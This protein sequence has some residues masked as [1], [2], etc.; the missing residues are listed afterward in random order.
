MIN[1][2]IL[3]EERCVPISSKADQILHDSTKRAIEKMLGEYHCK[4]LLYKLCSVDRLSEKELLTNYDLLKKSLYQ[5]LPT[6]AEIILRHVKYEMLRHAIFLVSDLTVEDIQNPILSITDILNLIRKEELMNFVREIPSH[7]HIVFFYE[8][9]KIRDKI[10]STFF[11]TDTISNRESN[12]PKGLLSSKPSNYNSQYD[13]N[14][15]G[16]G[17]NNILYGESL[18]LQEQKSLKSSLYDWVQSIHSSNK[19]QHTPTR[20]AN[21]DATWWLRNGRANEYIGFQKSLGRHIQYNVSAI[22][23]Y[24]ISKLNNEFLRTVVASHSYIMFDKPFMIYRNTRD[25]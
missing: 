8:N 11:H 15:F 12:P 4:L 10:L 9:E 21:Q 25:L 22:C 13:L 3:K 5:I 19:S 23:S 7:E 24:D 18:D 14:G 6:A 17:N 2:L 20:I 1:P 16:N